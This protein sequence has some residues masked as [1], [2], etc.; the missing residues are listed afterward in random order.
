VHSTVYTYTLNI[1][2]TKEIQL[3]GT[4]FPRVPRPPAYRDFA[5]DP[6]WWTCPQTPP[7]LLIPLVTLCSWQFSLKMFCFDPRHHA[8][9]DFV[10]GPT[11]DFRSPD[12]WPL[13]P[14]RHLA[15]LV[16]FLSMAS[17]WFAPADYFVVNVV[18]DVRLNVIFTLTLLAICTLGSVVKAADVLHVHCKPRMHTHRHT[19]TQFVVTCTFSCSCFNLF[20]HPKK[21][22]AGPTAG[23]SLPMQQ[24]QMPGGNSERHCDGQLLMPHAGTLLYK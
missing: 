23:I 16:I 6:H 18:V 22:L 2:T 12:P 7:G 19:I 4:L 9:R 1:C 14:T 21:L 20:L 3:L 17:G 8:Y 11:G 15:H 24:Q 5:S 13:H 10:L